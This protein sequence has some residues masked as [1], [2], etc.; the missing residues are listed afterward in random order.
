MPLPSAETTMHATI[1]TTT[2][3]TICY[4][5]CAAILLVVCLL[6][7]VRLHGYDG[8]TWLAIL[9]LVAG[10]QLLGHSALRPC[11]VWRC[12]SPASRW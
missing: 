3:T 6:G 2:Y 11:P 1:S 8:S 4:S 5:V 9:A 7:G 12:C 10:A